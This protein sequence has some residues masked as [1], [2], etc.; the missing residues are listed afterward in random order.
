VKTGTVGVNRLSYI[1]FDLSSIS[2]INSVKLQLYGN[3]S[4]TQ[5]GSA[6]TDVYAVAGTSWTESTITY[7]NAPAAGPSPLASATIAGTTGATYTWVVTAYVKAQKDAGNNTVSF[8]LK[9]PIATNAAVIF[10]SREAAS[11]GPVLLIS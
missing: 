4:N 8:V 1:K 9:D 11:G 3:L 2:T 10:N 6:V 7:S 5:N